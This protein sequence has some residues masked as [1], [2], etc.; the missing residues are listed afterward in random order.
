MTVPK[1]VEELISDNIDFEKDEW[2]LQGKNKFYVVG[3]ARMLQKYR[4]TAKSVFENVRE[5]LH[6]IEKRDWDE[7]WK[8]DWSEGVSRMQ[9]T[10]AQKQE[11]MRLP[12][13]V[14]MI[15]AAEKALKLMSES[16]QDHS[17]DPAAIYDELRIVPAAFHIDGFTESK[18]GEILAL[19]PSHKQK[20]LD[21]AD[22][23]N[24]ELLTDM[25]KGYAVTK[26]TAE[27][28]R[29]YIINNTP[30]RVGEISMSADDAGNASKSASRRE[31]LGLVEDYKS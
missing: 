10:K 29:E 16:E 3:F 13:A 26:K 6:E 22:Q 23:L 28:I 18:L 7:F 25:T 20:M 9:V 30:V 15:V 11:P 2:A 14:T 5:S 12:K 24:D 8:H 4:I 21:K 19:D 31:R 17:I 27:K 1:K